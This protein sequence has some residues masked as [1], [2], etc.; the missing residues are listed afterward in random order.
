MRPDSAAGSRETSVA[1]EVI[2]VVDDNELNVKLLRYILEKRGYAVRTA[3]SA[4]EAR[5]SVRADH[6]RLVLMDV[7]MPEVD[8]LTL[9]R[10]FK[11]DPDLRGI[12]VIAV[13]SHAMT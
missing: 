10:E 7:Q 4:A 3:G 1:G 9:T 13:T 8:G 5:A 6:P 2:L 11:A 12:P